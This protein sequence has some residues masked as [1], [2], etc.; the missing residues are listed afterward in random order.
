MV[1]RGEILMRIGKSKQKDARGRKI[2]VGPRGGEYVMHGKKKVYLFAK[3]SE[4]QPTRRCTL[5]QPLVNK[6]GR[7]V[8]EGKRGGLY[9]MSGSRKIYIK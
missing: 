7:A 5:M 9:V 4:G 3:H 2:R 6:K 8:Q 1:T